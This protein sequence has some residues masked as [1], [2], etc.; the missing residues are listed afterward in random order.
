MTIS[1]VDAGQTINAG[2]SSLVQNYETFLSLLTAQLKNQD[3]TSP[4]DSNAFTAQLVQ[5]SG[6]EQQLLTNDL[7]KTLVGQSENG[8]SNGVAYIGKTVTAAWSAN[9]LKDGS[10]TWSYELANNASDV[11]LEI[12]DSKGKVVWTGQAP[13]KTTGIH[14]FTWDGKAT[15][16]TQLPDGGV[17]SLKITSKQGDSDIASQVLIRGRTRG[18]EVYD[19]E[20]YLTI[21]GAIVPLAN[22]ISVEEQDQPASG[23]A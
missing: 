20:T 17:Y 14:D 7:L 8:L 10:A 18:V 2:R 21:G 19:G 16:G 6:V 9:A 12:F 11:K 22:V 13:D 4:V 23:N 5:M 15:D 1:A 3:P